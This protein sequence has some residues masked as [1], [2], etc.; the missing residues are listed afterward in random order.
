MNFKVE[1]DFV[2]KGIRCVVIFTRMGHRCGYVGV[3]EKSTIFEKGY[4]ELDFDVH[5]GLTYSGGGKD[6]KYPVESNLFWIGFDCAH[7]MDSSDI[8]KALE[9]GLIDEES[10]KQLTSIYMFQEGQIRSKSFCE[11][12][13]RSLVDQIL[14][15]G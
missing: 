14:E 3:D 13:C 10:Y 1:S 7:Y 2:Y 12:E 15:V 6:S 5:G 4:N 8:E 9:Y 11:D